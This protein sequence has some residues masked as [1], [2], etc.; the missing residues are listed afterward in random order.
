MSGENRRPPWTF[1]S[2]ED[3]S[4]NNHD[5]IP[6]HAHPREYDAQVLHDSRSTVRPGSA[7]QICPTRVFALLAAARCAARFR[8]LTH[9]I[10]ASREWRSGVSRCG[11]NRRN[12]F[13]TRLRQRLHGT[14]HRAR[15]TSNA[16]QLVAGNLD[17][18]WQEIV[19]QNSEPMTFV[20]S[21]KVGQV[22]VRLRSRKPHLFRIPSVG[23]F[24]LR[25]RRAILSECAERV[26]VLS[27]Q[28][29]RDEAVSAPHSGSPEV[30]SSPRPPAPLQSSP[31]R[32]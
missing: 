29:S 28:M 8:L 31:A 5:C 15:N 30:R 1:F 25:V 6:R 13:Q 14:N 16:L 11:F 22:R 23:I 4:Q 24:R 2:S 21:Q 10:L 9:G 12:R 26:L 3:P 27:G 7:G 19:G 17:I 18:W 32:V 20:S